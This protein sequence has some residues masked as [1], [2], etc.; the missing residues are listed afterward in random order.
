MT[1]DT[2]VN[3]FVHR[4]LPWPS[5]PRGSWTC[6]LWP[7]KEGGDPGNRADCHASGTADTHIIVSFRPTLLFHHPESIIKLES[8][9]TPPFPPL[10]VRGGVGGVIPWNIGYFP[11]AFFAAQ[12]PVAISIP[13]LD[14]SWTQSWP[15][16]MDPAAQTLSK[17]RSPVGSMGRK[18]ES[19]KIP[20]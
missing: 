15:A 2:E 14:F 4:R 10:N 11:S 8:P 5:E 1:T 9:I 7:W 17:S 16:K 12:Y 20:D 13:S 19:V 18:E 6:L 3:P